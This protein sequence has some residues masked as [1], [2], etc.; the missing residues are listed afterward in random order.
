MS[1]RP[2]HFSGGER[3]A[4]V[5]SDTLSANTVGSPL[6]LRPSLPATPRK[7]PSSTIFFT[8]RWSASPHASFLT[9]T[10]R[11]PVAS[12]RSKKTRAVEVAARADSARDAHRDPRSGI[13]LRQ[14]GRHLVA[15]LELAREGVDPLLAEGFEL[16]AAVFEGVGQKRLSGGSLPRSPQG[17]GRAGVYGRRIEFRS[18]GSHG[19]SL[20]CKGRTVSYLKAP[21][22]S[23]GARSDDG[24]PAKRRRFETVDTLSES[25]QHS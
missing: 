1:V 14:G 20:L 12:T 9:I 8:R 11:R 2:C 13:D 6:L 25:D 3:S 21:R 22:V 19:E 24:P 15:A 17:N 5:S 16:L 4:F 18:R 10:C 7:S 23:P